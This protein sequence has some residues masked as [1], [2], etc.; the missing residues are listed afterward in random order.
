MAQ[1]E[2]N[3]MWQKMNHLNHT[4]YLAACYVEKKNYYQKKWSQNLSF[5]HILTQMCVCITNNYWEGT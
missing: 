4:Y 1:I 5:S 3:Y 2:F